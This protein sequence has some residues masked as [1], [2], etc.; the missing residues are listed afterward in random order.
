MCTLYRRHNYPNI[1]NYLLNIYI[2]KGMKS[3]DQS[4]RKKEA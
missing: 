2:S 1:N 4:E 3:D